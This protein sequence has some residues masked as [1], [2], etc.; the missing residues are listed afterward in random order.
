MIAVRAS[1]PSVMD[2][3]LLSGMAWTNANTWFGFAGLA[4]T[5][6]LAG[7]LEGLLP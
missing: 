6:L 7:V 4:A 2:R 1:R 3:I 5:V